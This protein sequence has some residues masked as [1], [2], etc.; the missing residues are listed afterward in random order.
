MLRLDSYRKIGYTSLAI[1]ED[2]KFEALDKLL[3]LNLKMIQK[4]YIGFN[5]TQKK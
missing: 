1:E 4:T 5:I 2:A 3:V